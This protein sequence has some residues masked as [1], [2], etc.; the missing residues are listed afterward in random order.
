MRPKD[1]AV[2]PFFDKRASA[3]VLIIPDRQPQYKRRLSWD[4]GRL[5][6]DIGQKLRR[7]S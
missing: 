2:V 6:L 5:S 7:F 4:I 1:P 3:R